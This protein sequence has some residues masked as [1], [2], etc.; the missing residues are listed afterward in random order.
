MKKWFV[1]AKNAKGEDY[2]KFQALDAE[3]IKAL[4][5]DDLIDYHQAKLADD[6]AKLDAIIADVEK[7]ATKE[8][9][10]AIA[11]SVTDTRDEIMK[12]VIKQGETL[13]EMARK[14][15]APTVQK[16]E[17]EKV[18]EA[19]KEAL[20][21]IKSG[22]RKEGLSMTIAL[23]AV[24]TQT[25]GD[26]DAGS[27]FAQMRPGVIDQPVRR[28]RF[29]ELFG[30]I[31]L[32]TEVLKYV[33]QDSVVRDAQ[34]V[35]NCT[36][37]TTSLTKETLLVS[38][39]EPVKVK[40]MIRACI[41][42]LDDYAFMQSRINRLLSQSVTLRVDEQLLLGT[43]I[44]PEMN[45][46][47]SVASEFSA[48]NPILVLTTSIQAANFVD[49]ILGMAT[50]IEMLGLENSF[51]PDTVVVNRGDWFKLVESDK[52]L[53]NNYLDSRVTRVGPSIL[54]GDL[55]VVTSPIVVANTVY[56]FD[57]SQGEIV[58][59]RQ[60]VIDIAFENGTDWESDIVSLKGSE[61]L[62]FLVP[63]EVANAFMKSGDVAAAIT[64]ITAL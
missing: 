23:K 38:S 10:A 5:E 56:V 50:Q 31:P 28:P 33:E 6:K 9:I 2:N 48:A 59:R 35:A 40:D 34:N 45:S 52:D 7:K 4:S 18:F 15:G 19:N 58:D 22:K 17:L 21:D 26:I 1:V 61:R 37:I 42:F 44:A 47:D 54:I 36:A 62:N 53:N 24:V 30:T 46:I 27:D 14:N 25:Y 41:D 51:R 11:K 43:G 32:S 20:T 49:L 16:S 13:A 63:N 8:E 39:I 3:A 57:S 60:L 55:E 29:R 12:A 64:A